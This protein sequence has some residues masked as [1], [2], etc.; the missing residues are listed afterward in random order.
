MTNFRNFSDAGKFIF[1]EIKEKITPFVIDLKFSIKGI[2][3]RELFLFLKR[4]CL[5]FQ[6]EGEI[7]FCLKK[8][9]SLLS[10]SHLI[11]KR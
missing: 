6:V 3:S 11:L 1:K 7:L 8:S 4:I 5:R 9:G 2:F 10:K